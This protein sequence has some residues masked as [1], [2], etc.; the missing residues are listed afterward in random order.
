MKNII[1]STM[2]ILLLASPAFGHQVSEDEVAR[3]LKQLP[4]TQ[5]GQEGEVLE[6]NSFFPRERLLVGIPVMIST[7]SVCTDFVGQQTRKFAKVVEITAMG[8]DSGLVQACIEI[9]PMPVK[10]YL[11]VE[12]T[13]FSEHLP[14]GTNVLRK[15]VKINGV[16]YRVS[17]DTVTERVKIRKAIQL[18]VIEFGTE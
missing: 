5:V 3:N 16:K 15:L 7:G 4:I 13:H 1:Q 14:I 10:K 2:V 17:V 12:F 8:S 11:T 6:R 18:P 9:F